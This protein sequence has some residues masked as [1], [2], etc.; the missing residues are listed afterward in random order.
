[1][2]ALFLWLQSR[3]FGDLLSGLEYPSNF[4]LQQIKDKSGYNLV[5][6][7]I[8]NF[9]RLL[10]SFES[11]SKTIYRGI[12]KNDDVYKQIQSGK[13]SIVTKRYY[14]CTKNINIGKSFGQ[15]ILLIIN[16]KRNFNISKHSR[17]EEIVLDKS[18]RLN[19][20]S[21]RTENEHEIIELSL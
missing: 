4:R 11:Y 14:S 16:C 12:F 8:E 21:M 13:T 9:S 3:E 6:N 15:K 5:R 17:E 7:D 2:R 18:V 1:M 20:V 19:V 10:S